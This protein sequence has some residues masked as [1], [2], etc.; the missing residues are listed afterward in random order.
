MHPFRHGIEMLISNIQSNAPD[1][2]VVFPALPM[3]FLHRNSIINIF[4]L[5]FLTDAVMSLWER[6]KKI[7]ANSRSNA[8][9]VE[10]KTK[11]VAG[12][13]SSNSKNN[14]V[15]PVNCLA[16]DHDYFRSM[17]EDFDINDDVLLSAD[18]VHPNV[19]MYAKWADLVGDKLWE[20]IEHCT[21]DIPRIEVKYSNLLS[22]ETN[23][24]AQHRQ[25]NASQQ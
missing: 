24:D 10:L 12:W 14:E 17:A 25:A 3:Q 18:G 19:L 21:S 13:Y 15:E 4:P 16:G 8:M 1:A 2:L 7:V 22:Q 6:Q 5:G 23:K 20:R 9:Y 11:E